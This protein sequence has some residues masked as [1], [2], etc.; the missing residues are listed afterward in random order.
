MIAN[1]ADRE[2][3]CQEIFFKVYRSLPSF[4]LECKIS[5]WI[6]R[7][8]YNTCINHLQK[9]RTPLYEDHKSISNIATEAQQPDIF[10]EEKDISTR[11]QTEIN[12]MDVRYRT[13]LTLYHLNEM[14]YSEIGEIM[15]LPE[16]TVKS[17]L[18]RARRQLKERL[19]SKYREEELCHTNT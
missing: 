14:S 10:I 9:M 18:F 17:Y 2:D 4:R 8:A 6:G 13:I 5:T 3:L 7:I 11:V 12:K 1:N 16:G 19:M 15:N